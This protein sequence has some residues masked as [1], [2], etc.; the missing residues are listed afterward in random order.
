MT[1]SQALD[2][3][4]HITERGSNVRT[5]FKAGLLVFLS[6]AYII[7][8][9]PSMMA[10]A[11]MDEAVCYT[12]TILMSII[13]TLLMALYAKFPVALA[14]TMGVNAFFV[15]TVVL[16]MGYQWD[17]AL[18]AVF[19]SGVVFFLLAVSGVR[20]RVLDQIPNEFRHGITAGIGCFIVFIGLQNAGII[21]DSTTLVGLGDMT[22]P[23]VLLAFLCILLTLFMYARKVTG[24]ILIGMVASVV[25]GVAFGIIP[26]PDSIVSTP[27]VPDF[28]AFLDGFTPDIM[29]FEYLMVVISFVFVQFFD[30]AGTLMAVGERAG[31]IDDD[32]NIQ[33]DRALVADSA[34]SVLSGIAG[35]T[36][37]GS[38]AESTV[39]IEAGGRTGLTALVVA[40][41]FAVALFLGPLFSIV[42]YSCTVGAMMIVGAA[43][44]TQLRYVDWKDWPLTVA[45]LSTMLMMVLTFSITDGIAFG[46]VF[47]CVAM[48][49][50]GRRREISPIIYGLAALSMIYFIVMAMAL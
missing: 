24:A 29:N 4:F 44:I 13:A 43:M 33:C 5:E 42:D 22:S 35:T 1:I 18:L 37:V 26:L 32:G 47:Y 30:S 34:A 20:K 9:N 17:E 14:P 40:M 48:L 28:G 38:Y 3:Y 8:V 23:A 39:G 12:A 45:V 25:T 19:L 31:I 7:A 16:T 15:Y 49:G 2:S 6:M 50:A 36:P 46:I 41:L 10:E 21:V 11:G 27:A